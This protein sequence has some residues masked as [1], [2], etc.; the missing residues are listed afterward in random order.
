MEKERV[1]EEREGS[2]ME[3]ERVREERVGRGC[4]PVLLCLSCSF[5]L[6]PLQSHKGLHG[7]E[8]EGQ[9]S[10]DLQ[11]HVHNPVDTFTIDIKLRSG[12]RDMSKRKRDA[13]ADQ[14]GSY[15][16]RG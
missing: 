5:P 11:T 4:R 15:G 1:G 2:K 12:G 14:K 8:Q 9:S 6:L 16:E 3:K 13:L 7:R 10:L